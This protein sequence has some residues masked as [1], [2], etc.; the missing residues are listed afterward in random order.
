MINYYHN[1]HSVIPTLYFTHKLLKKIIINNNFVRISKNILFK[2]LFFYKN[3]NKCIAC[4]F[5]F[6]LPSVSVGVG[7]TIGEAGW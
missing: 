1:H 3:C 7:K 2:I 6:I 4:P 5:D